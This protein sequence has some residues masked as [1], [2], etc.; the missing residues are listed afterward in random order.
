MNDSIRDAVSYLDENKPRGIQIDFLPSDGHHIRAYL[1]MPGESGSYRRCPRE[2]TQILRDRDE[3]N[4][5][6]AAFGQNTSL[7]KLQLRDG[8]RRPY[9]I[10]NESYECI[11]AIYRGLELNSS[12]ENIE[13][14]LDLMNDETLPSFNLRDAQ[15]KGSLKIFKLCDGRMNNN[16]SHIISSFLENTSLQCFD[17]SSVAFDAFNEQSFG[18]IISACTK[19]QA[20]D[21]ECNTI[22]QYTTVAS[23]LRNPIVNLSVI[24]FHFES[25]DEEKLSIIAAGLARNTTLKFLVLGFYGMS[26]GDTDTSILAKALCDASSIE[27]IH[28]SNHTLKHVAP[29][30]KMLPIVLDCLKLNEIEDKDKVIRKKIAKYYFIGD[31]DISPFAKMP[32]SVLPKVLSLIEEDDE[33][34]QSAIFRM[35]KL[36]PE[37]CSFL[38]GDVGNATGLNGSKNDHDNC[39]KRLK[40]DK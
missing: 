14:D 24:S 17:I 40:I 20:L 28:T 6:G 29:T 10:D 38:S 30:E 8:L 32:V 26:I 11:E 22:S 25:M 23:L 19:V 36:I 4:R 39:N 13:I 35:L 9:H 37:L 21:V 16:Q 1:R 5:L 18:R 34:Q 2:F 15:F 27:S 12:L 7:E 31:F 33:N 3:W